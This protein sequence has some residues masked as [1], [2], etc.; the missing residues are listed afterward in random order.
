MNML[1]AMLVASTA[2]LSA[3]LPY[4]DDYWRSIPVDQASVKA[5]SDDALRVGDFI[6]VKT[7]NGKSYHFNVVELGKDGFWG[8]QK[9]DRRHWVTYSSLKRMQAQRQRIRILAASTPGLGF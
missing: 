4:L 5:K 6:R 9:T 3:C 1:R 8:T 2:L 7:L